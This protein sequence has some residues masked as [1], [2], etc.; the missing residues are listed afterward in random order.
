MAWWQLG[1][2]W[3]GGMWI[4]VWFGRCR[5]GFGFTSQQSGRSHD[6]FHDGLVPRATAQVPLNGLVDLR[7]GRTRRLVQQGL[8]RDEETWRAETTL[9]APMFCKAG[10]DGRQMMAFGEAFDRGDGS[11]FDVTRERHAREPRLSVNE[12][13]ATAARAQIASAL[14]AQLPDVVTQDIQK[15]CVA[16]SQYFD[17]AVVDLS[18][19]NGVRCLRQHGDACFTDH[20]LTAPWSCL[21]PL[22]IGLMR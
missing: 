21:H 20:H 10:L 7:L 6:G 18:T 17:A 5:G 2:F 8:R 16:G 3:P 19:P 12:D 13:R 14:D 15:N 22:R 9:R 11:A 1:L 4:G